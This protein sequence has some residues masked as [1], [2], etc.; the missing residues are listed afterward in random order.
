MHHLRDK[1]FNIIPLKDVVM[2]LRRKLPLP[3]RSIVITFDDGFKNFYD[4]AYPILN[5]LGFSATVFLVPGHCGK[6]NK[7]EGQSEKV[8]ILDL[9]GWEE[10]REMANNGIDFGA[11]TMNHADLPE[12]SIERASEEVVNSKQMI[13][14]NLGKNVQ[15]FAY[16]YGSLN[17][18]IKAVIKNNFLAACSVRLDVVNINSDIFALPRVEMYYFSDNNLFTWL[19]TSKFSF[20]VK[21]RNSMRLFRRQISFITGG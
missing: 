8:P 5:N 12:L 21:I 17:S 4:V 7:W 9:L 20:Y 14:K 1:D 19:G 6:N 11:H 16:P 3:P 13:E 10:I 18:E 15:F 2:C